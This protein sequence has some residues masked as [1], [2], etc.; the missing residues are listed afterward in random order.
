MIKKFLKKILNIFNYKIISNN[1]WNKRVENLIVEATDDELNKF[2][3]INEISLTSLPNR[4]SLYQSLKYI[5]ENKI[6]GDLVETGVFKG[7]NLVLINDFLNQFKIEKK[8]Y[9]YDTY[10]GQPE[11]TNFDFDIKGKSML[12]KYSDGKKKNL[13]TV[14][15]SLDNV[16]KNIEKYS[17]YDLSKLLFVKGKV[18]DTLIDEKNIPAKISLLR[19]D[20]DF[21]ESIKISLEIL[22]P[23]LSKGGILIIDDYGHFKG[24]KLAVD[25]FFQDQKKILM[26]RVDYTCR[27]IVKP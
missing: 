13:N 23:R 15:C 25:N 17:N 24:A 18:E 8:I 9:A 6:E 14:F 3:K 21:Y 27:L 1:N 12:E 20:T 26:H 19:L 5:Y 11:P 4:W 2:D 10:S 16:K 22:Y 7:A